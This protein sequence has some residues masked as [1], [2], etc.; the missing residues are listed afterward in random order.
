MQRIAVAGLYLRI[1]NDAAKSWTLH[2]LEVDRRRDIGLGAYPAVAK[3]APNL[4]VPNHRFD[5]S[6]FANFSLNSRPAGD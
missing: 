4:C 5:G 2:A 6:I 1:R 3:H